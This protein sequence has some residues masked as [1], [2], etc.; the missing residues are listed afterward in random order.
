[1][2]RV[3]LQKRN[4]ELTFRQPLYFKR[5]KVKERT[6]AREDTAVVN[7]RHRFFFSRQMLT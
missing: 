1:M 4:V 5:S 7:V 3:K 6:V 2:S